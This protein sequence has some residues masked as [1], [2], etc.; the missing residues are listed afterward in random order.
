MTN[1]LT[2]K[3]ESNEEGFQARPILDLDLT[4]LN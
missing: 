3:F 1:S 4:Q 2:D